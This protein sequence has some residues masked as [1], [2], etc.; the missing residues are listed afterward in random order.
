MWEVHYSL[1]AS[2]YLEDNGSLISNLFFA[3]ESLADSAGIPTTR[4]FDEMQGLYYW[5]V[6]DHLIVYRRI[7][8]QKI[9]RI[10]FIKPDF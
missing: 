8:T 6:E 9:A 3:M 7:E 4:S 2:T 5:L 1:E 10:I